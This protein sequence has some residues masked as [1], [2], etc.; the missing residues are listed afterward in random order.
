MN[1]NGSSS[2]AGRKV[3]QSEPESLEHELH[4]ELN[5]TRVVAVLI[6][7]CKSR[8]ARILIG[9]P[10]HGVIEGIDRFDADLQARSARDHFDRP[11]LSDN[12]KFQSVGRVPEAAWPVGDQPSLL[13]RHRSVAS[14]LR[15]ST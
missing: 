3:F 4:A 15:A 10:E 2:V 5:V 7:D 1:A 6:D 13:H 14:S 8:V 9:I 12:L 11:Y